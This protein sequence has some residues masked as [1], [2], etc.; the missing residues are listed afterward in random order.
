MTKP[1]TTKYRGARLE[2][3]HKTAAGL[4]RLGSLDKK[5]DARF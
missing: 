2:V 5:N 1:A 3:L 4:A